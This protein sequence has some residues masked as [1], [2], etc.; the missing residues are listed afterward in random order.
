[1]KLVTFIRKGS[2]EEE[3]GLLRGEG[4]L[5]L[6][7]A[8]FSFA[9]MN[10]LICRST[11]EERAAMA[12]AEGKALPLGDVT[13]LS[14]I[15]RPMQD[16]LCLGLNYAEHVKEASGFSRDAFGLEV[17]APIFFSKRVSF[18]QG[19][20]APIPAHRDLTAQLDYENEL[21]VIIGRDADHVGEAEA[22]DHIFGYTI[23]NDVTAREL[24]T[25]HKQWHFGKSLEGFCP[26]GPC[27][28]T[29]DELPWPPAQRIRTTLNGRLMQDSRT[30][31]LIHSI[32]EIVS[33]LSQGFVLRAGSIIATG[34][35]K[36]VL[37]GAGGGRFLQPGDE[38][39]CA[40]EG[41]GELR[42]T[43]E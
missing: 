28:V 33:V 26:M 38:I 12:A 29:A 24:Q 1:M 32:G 5:P 27:I 31:C 7:E 36:G 15:P 35:P 43:V 20:D 3:L 2:A 21:A 23:L 11:K 25:R 34:T 19:P 30:D 6:R 9:D 14:P 18:S 8:G 10:D 22:R 17:S 37:M 39:V 16:V 4:V 13:L 41:I 42:N 40:I